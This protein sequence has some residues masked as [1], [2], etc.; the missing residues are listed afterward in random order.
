[1]TAEPGLLRLAD[2]PG[3]LPSPGCPDD[4]WV[5][6]LATLGPVRD[7]AVGRLHAL[8]VRAA[9][10]QVSRM[11]MAAGL[12]VVRVEDLVQTAA[13]EATM[14]V[15]SR[16]DAFEGRSRFTTWAYKFGILC[17]GV[18]VRR[19]VWRD[20][21]IELRDVPEPAAGLAGSPDAY[22]EGRELAGAVREAMLHVLT[23]HQRRI[24]LAL[25]VDE[26]PI[27]VLAER[28]GCTRGALYKTLHDARK[29]LRGHLVSE[30]FLEARS[31]EEVGR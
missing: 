27:D 1:V 28:L 19:A 31:V 3:T 4:E 23:P 15:L 29:R 26:V 30:G 25:L 17:A 10:H 6:R 18:E 21:N 5:A 13:N 11:P 8:M 16:L 22:S 2:A 9:R 7:D 14:A 24:A 12:G 20:R